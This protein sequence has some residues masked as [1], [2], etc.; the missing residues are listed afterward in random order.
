MEEKVLDILEEIC[1]DEVVR[2]DLDIQLFEMGLLD[3]LA[4]AELLVMIEEEFN[5]EILLTEL[6]RSQ[7]ETPNKLIAYLKDKGVN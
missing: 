4:V 1:E 3:S 7:I 5:I 2:E 6:D